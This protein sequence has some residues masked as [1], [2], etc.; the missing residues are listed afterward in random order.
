M[1]VKGVS[2]DS[3]DGP[4]TSGLGKGSPTLRRYKRGKKI[5]NGTNAILASYKANHENQEHLPYN[6]LVCQR[7]IRQE[8]RL[9]RVLDPDNPRTR[10]T[11]TKQGFAINY[12]GRDPSSNETNVHFRFYE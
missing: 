9:V 4:D 11:I 5:P 1:P 10:H 6:E 3:D 7:D 8:A 2:R 12:G